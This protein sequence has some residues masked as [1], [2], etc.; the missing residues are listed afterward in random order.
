MQRSEVSRSAL[1]FYDTLCNRGYY[2]V[3]LPIQYAALLCTT[4]TGTGQPADQLVE[5]PPAPARS[6]DRSYYDL[7][8]TEQ[9][10]C[11]VSS[12]SG[13][14]QAGGARSRAGL[15]GF[16]KSPFLVEIRSSF[17]TLHES[18]GLI[19]WI[20]FRQTPS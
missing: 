6:Q 2:S 3:A 8:E 16:F 11:G 7:P 1:R 4:G 17:G 5:N 10:F 12:A 19:V 9:R 18:C 15:A 13:V 20:T 14:G